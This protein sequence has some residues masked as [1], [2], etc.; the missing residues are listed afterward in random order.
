MPTFVLRYIIRNYCIQQWQARLILQFQFRSDPSVSYKMKL[1]VRFVIINAPEPQD[2]G[3]N[4][5]SN[6]LF[7]L[8][9]IVA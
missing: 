5:R 6:F 3:T 8:S 2:I 7:P 4:T 1:Y 9:N